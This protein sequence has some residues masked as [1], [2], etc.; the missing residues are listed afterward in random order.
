M[1]TKAKT[2][3]TGEE[4][5][6]PAPAPKTSFKWII[7]GVLVLA[8]LGGGGA[9]AWFK[10]M[11]PHKAEA[12]PGETTQTEVKVE[13][14]AGEKTGEKTGEQSGPPTK[15]GPIFDLDPFIVNLADA[16][17]RFLKVTMKLELDGAP[18][19]AEVSERMPQVR[20][21]VL[22]LLSSKE[23]QA[24]KPTSGKLQL[25]DE[26]LQRI[27]SLLAN[28]QARNAYFTEFVVQ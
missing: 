12:K 4:T 26:I 18:A 24:L 11:A 10:F 2:D 14:K 21:A 28:G 5:P 8:V 6:A 3:D 23:S 15:I 20:D 27:N 1:A 19:K 13:G 9:F 16:E 22:I 7:V 17:P 25:R